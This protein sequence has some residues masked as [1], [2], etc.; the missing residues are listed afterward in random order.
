MASILVIEDD[1]QFREMLKR[2]LEDEGHA[3]TEA[4]NGIEG[5]DYYRNSPTE[6]VIIDLFMPE[7]EGI[8]TIRE[9]KKDFPESKIIAISGGGRKGI[10]H[11]LETAKMIGADRALSKPF[12]PPELFDIIKEMLEKQ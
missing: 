4:A 11:I 7:K 10:F 2:L 3:I 8:E 5:I 9:L 6:L 12:D 1:E